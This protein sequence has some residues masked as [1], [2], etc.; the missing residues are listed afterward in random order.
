MVAANALELSDVEDA[1]YVAA[2]ENGLVADDG[3]RQCWATI[4][5]GLGSGMP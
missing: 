2:S 4:R 1:L 5:S 3:A